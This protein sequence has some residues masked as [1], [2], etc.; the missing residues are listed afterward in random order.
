L[1]LDYLKCLF[2]FASGIYR[3]YGFILVIAIFGVDYKLQY[4]VK[5]PKKL[6]KGTVGYGISV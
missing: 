4:F 5:Y 2:E 6:E 3:L 1:D